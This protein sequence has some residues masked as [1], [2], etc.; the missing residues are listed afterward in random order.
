MTPE[1][2]I[3][4]V[5]ITTEEKHNS[6]ELIKL[7][8]KRRNSGIDVESIIGDGT[9]SEESNLKYCNE[10]EIK[11]VSKSVTHSN[12]KNN[13]D[14]EYNKDA[15]MYVCKIGITLQRATTLFLFNIKRIIKLNE[16][17]IKIVSYNYLLLFFC[18]T[19]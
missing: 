8:E 12:C 14:F 15:G 1:R 10:N 2:I 16:E 11:N 9:Y 13:I 5:T 18:I 7:I 4:A 3:T 17:K 6:K 19:H